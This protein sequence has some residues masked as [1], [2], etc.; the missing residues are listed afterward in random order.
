MAFGRGR[1]CKAGDFKSR[2]GLAKFFIRPKIVI[3]TTQR[4]LPMAAQSQ[5]L[6]R[7]IDILSGFYSPETESVGTLVTNTF[8]LL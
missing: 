6:S 4:L 2:E 3:F 5:L 8:G 7:V 1:R